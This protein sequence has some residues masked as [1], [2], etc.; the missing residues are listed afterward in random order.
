M[1]SEMMTIIIVTKHSQTQLTRVELI[2]MM[3]DDNLSF[4]GLFK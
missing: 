1:Q 2:L 3:T 4:R